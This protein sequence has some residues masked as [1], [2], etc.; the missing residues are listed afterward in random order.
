MMA[1]KHVSVYQLAV[2]LVDL[3]QSM[4]T[5]LNYMRV[6]HVAL[7]RSLSPRGLLIWRRGIFQLNMVSRGQIFPL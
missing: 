3:I 2:V 5:V 6:G 1:I 4:I 7:V